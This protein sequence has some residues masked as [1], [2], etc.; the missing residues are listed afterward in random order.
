M[1]SPAPGPLPIT[2][3]EERE[4]SGSYSGSEMIGL[5]MTGITSVHSSSTIP[6]HKEG[7]RNCY[8]TM[9]AEPWGGRELEYLAKIA[10][11]FHTFLPLF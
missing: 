2:M 7:G 11:V 1:E 5:E 3:A 4:A 6:G 10:N 8:L 9:D